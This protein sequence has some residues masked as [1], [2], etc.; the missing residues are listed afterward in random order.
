MKAHMA[1]RDV[2]STSRICL[3][4]GVSTACYETLRGCL[5]KWLRSRSAR[6]QQSGSH[7]IRIVAAA[8][9]CFAFVPRRAADVNPEELGHGNLDVPTVFGGRVGGAGPKAVRNS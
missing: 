4:P 7:A 3:V 5:N 1:S 8:R 2:V 6:F 9:T